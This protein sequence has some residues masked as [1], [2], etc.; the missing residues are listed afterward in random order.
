M[1]QQFIDR[2]IREDQ[3]AFSQRETW[4]FLWQQCADLMLP[5]MAE[6]THKLSPGQKRDR[7]IFDS[8]GVAVN[9]KFAAR[10]F[11]FLTGEG[12]PWFALRVPDDKLDSNV[13]I[14]TW[15]DEV[16]RIMMGAFNSPWLGFSTASE[17]KFIQLGAFGT[18]P[19]F[20]GERNGLPYFQSEFLG[21][22]AI[23]T[24]DRGQ[25]AGVYRRYSDT[26]FQIADKFGSNNLPKLVLEALRSDPQKKFTC[27]HIVRPRYEDDPP[28][29]AQFPFISAYICLDDKA[30]L[31]PLRG[32]FEQPWI[33]ARWARSPNEV[34]GRGPGI[35]ALA[36]VQ[37]L[38]EVVRDTVR[39]IHKQVDP[40]I[41]VSDDGTLPPRANMR[42]GGYWYGRQNPA[43]KWNIE[44][45]PSAGR[46]EAAERLISE[47]R[48]RI[49]NHFLLD[50]FDLPPKIS[51]DGSVVHMSA[52][53]FAGRQR[54][55][56]QFV[57]PSLARLR[58]E[59]LMPTV[60][61]TFSILMRN[62]HLPPPPSAVLQSGIIPEYVS[63]LAIAQKA[64]EADTI[65]QFFGH[66]G[67]LAQ[68]DPRVLDIIN[69]ERT[70]ELLAKADHVPMKM[71]NTKQERD[72]IKFDREQAQQEQIEAEQLQATA[73]A[74]KDSAT[75]LKLLGEA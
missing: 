16:T 15:L 28:T 36:D 30:F 32:F 31:R 12:Q 5:T 47:L 73:A 27:L 60:K 62:G 48:D 19:M 22:V 63:P 44:Q 1:A 21:N 20:I 66:I 64:H 9:Q 29:F 45:V 3:A 10:V 40:N 42:P 25:V 46:P 11:G 34:Y 2:L 49:R 4:E 58:A 52:T 38:Q 65:M 70:T 50:L 71:L 67:P 54:Q 37:Q 39:L 14:R 59:D 8:T 17:E 13:Q 6:F 69:P 68:V 74:S 61:R 53:E 72:Q 33:I 56:L 24:D 26:A 43:G 57:G 23:W 18:A 35:W 55:Q 41:L 51:D 75:A 7:K